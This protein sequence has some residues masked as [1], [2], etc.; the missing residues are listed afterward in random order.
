MLLLFVLQ[1]VEHQS[2]VARLQ[3]LLE[4]GGIYIDDDILFLKSFDELRNHQT[5]LAEEN[6]DAL[7]NGVILHKIL[8]KN[9]PQNPGFFI[10][11]FKNTKTSMILD[12]VIV[13][14][15]YFG[16]CGDSFRQ[17]LQL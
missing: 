2:D 8:H 7:G 15:L 14:A 5:V 17:Q 10:D 4:I 6:Y 13:P 11:G 9:P 1:K 16:P 3:I 12:G